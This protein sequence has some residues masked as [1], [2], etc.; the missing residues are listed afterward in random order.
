MFALK[1]NL[2]LKDKILHTNAC[3]DFTLLSKKD[4]V[5]LMG[6]PEWDIF[7]WHIDSVIIYQ[8]YH[9]GI[10]MVNLDSSY[11]IYHIEHNKGSGWT[12]EGAELLFSRLDKNE[13]ECLDDADLEE[14]F[15]QQYINKKHGRKTT[16]NQT[17]G[18]PHVSFPEK[19]TT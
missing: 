17:W 4:W 2:Y 11:R 13:I 10:K 3:G 14:I 18:D 12:P 7:S 16:Y 15:F 1:Q 6:Y 19:L 5:R 8:A 9:N